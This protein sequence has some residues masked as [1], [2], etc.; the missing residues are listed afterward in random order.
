LDA[1]TTYARDVRFRPEVFFLGRT[2][3]AG[4]VRNPLGAVVRRCA[5]VTEGSLHEAYDA[6]HFDETFT[7][8]DGEIDV[9]RWA[10]TCSGGDEYLA[11]EAKAGS[12]IVG[13]RAGDDYVLS[14]Q[15]EAGRAKGALAPRFFTRFTLLS[16]DVALKSAK[17]SILGVPVGLMT[18]VHR[19]VGG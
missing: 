3:G 14:F 11:A 6:I 19:R 9:W 2:E 7:Y 16:P 18:A 4:V 8:E 13:R 10:M 5:I 12:R 15:R 1:R 17:V